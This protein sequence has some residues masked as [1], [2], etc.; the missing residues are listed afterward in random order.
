[1]PLNLVHISVEGQHNFQNMVTKRTKF[2]FLH[3]EL[4]Y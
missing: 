2:I 4:L 1:M 3:D